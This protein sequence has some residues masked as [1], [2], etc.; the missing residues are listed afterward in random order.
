MPLSTIFQLYRCGQFLL[1]EETRENHRPDSRKSLT[2]FTTYNVMMYQVHV[3]LP[4]SEIGS[5]NVSGDR[6]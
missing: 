3:H 1:M 6:H 5:H 2:N 4:M